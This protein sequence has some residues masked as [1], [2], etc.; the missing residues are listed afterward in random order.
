MDTVKKLHPNATRLELTQDVEV[1]G[2]LEPLE[3]EKGTEVVYL[4]DGDEPGV[5]SVCGP[6]GRVVRLPA[7]LFRLAE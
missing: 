6:G 2:L 1:F 7:K 5:H 3:W 4:G